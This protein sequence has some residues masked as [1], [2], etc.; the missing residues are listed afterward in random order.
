MRAA[1]AERRKI[2]CYRIVDSTS[3]CKA[4]FDEDLPD[5]VDSTSDCKVGLCGD[6]PD[7]VDSTSDCKAKFDEDLQSIVDSTIDYAANAAT[8]RRLQAPNVWPVSA[9]PCL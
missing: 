4:G 1:S 6:L 2:F 9:M 7:A 3:D 8:P 5:V